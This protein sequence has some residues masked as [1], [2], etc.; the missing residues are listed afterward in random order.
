MD[1]ETKFGIMRVP[2]TEDMFVS[3]LSAED[4]EEVF[5][6]TEATFY[7]GSI[8]NLTKVGFLRFREHSCYEEISDIL[9]E[10]IVYCE[11]A[12][13]AYRDSLEN[14]MCEG[15]MYLEE[16]HVEDTHRGKAYGEHML[17]W[18]CNKNEDTEKIILSTD[19]RKDW[20]FN[21]YKDRM[22]G[23]T[24]LSILNR[25]MVFIKA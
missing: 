5:E 8:N 20:L 2:Y 25:T 24:L 11:M 4:M 18:L 12:V 1:K 15:D 19:S 21:Y 23:F 16:M 17:K 13:H 9:E 14:N 7:T 22:Y 10:A 3:V 6:M